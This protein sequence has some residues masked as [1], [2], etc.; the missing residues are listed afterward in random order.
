MIFKNLL[1][2]KGR[3][4]LTMIEI[5]IGVTAIIALG[6]MANGVESG[7][8]K[9]LTGSQA[10]LVL[11]QPD[12][13][14]LSLSSIDETITEQLQAMPEVAR[15][16]GM[17]EGIVQ[18]EGAPYFFVFGYPKDSFVLPRF[19]IIEGVGTD[20]H[21]LRNMRGKPIW[22]GKAASQAMKKKPG[23]IVRLN[24]SAYRV[25]GIF[26]TGEAFE[27]GG[28]VLMLP[29]AQAMLGQER[30][31]SVMYIQLKDKSMG[32]RLQ[33]R[34]ARLWPDLDMTSTADLSSRQ[35][36]GT[37]LQIYVWVIAGLAIVIGGVGMMNAQLMSVFER[38]REIG[39]LRA[40]GW[41]SLRVMG[42]I[43]GES[44]L[45][46]ILGGMLGVFLGWLSLKAAS[47]F[48]SAFGASSSSIDAGL[49]IRAFGTVTVLG[50]VGGL[51]PGLRAARL[52]PV[53]ALR[54]EGGSLN[55]RVV[56]LPVGGMATQSLWQR[57]A[58][59][60]LTLA[61]I[62]ITIGAIMLLDGISGS[63]TGM[64][65][66]MAGGAQIMLEQANVSDTS[67]S[68][69]DERVGDKIAA[70]P[71]V[72]AVA[73][74]TFTAIVMNETGFFM[75]IGQAPNEPGINSYRVIDGRPIVSNHEIMI[76]QQVATALN[77]HVGDT[78]TLSGVRYRIVGIYNAKLSFMEL[79]GVMTLRDAQN[80]TGKPRKVTMYQVWVKNPRQAAEVRDEINRMFPEVHASLSGEFADNMP[81]LQN[82]A[83][84]VN[85]IS[86]MAILVGGLGMM[87]TMLM[88]VL[89]RT[90]E[91]GVLRALGWRRR[92]ILSLIIREAALLGI[93]GGAVGMLIAVGIGVLLAKSGGMA[94][95]MTPQWSLD[96]FARA[97]IVAISLGVVGGLYPALRGTQLQPVEA[98]RYE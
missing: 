51:Y 86:F 74:M 3:T 32:D 7:Y 43:L 77:K 98:L 71:A 94:S 66:G 5:A 1:R 54:Y 38:T 28:A 47:G 88:A 81:D 8:G 18:A 9:A 20:S 35:N 67:Y 92:D 25:A 42:M 34:A 80:F 26:T 64:M 84:M 85:G 12:A 53:E 48:V 69:I 68:A 21:E 10:D 33:E 29:D 30:H 58:R 46:G 4:F 50:L 57:K 91:I 90:R 44:V 52:E 76:G 11:S 45:I 65:E 13:Y 97:L 62:G 79:G 70:L 82:T 40:V 19:Q 73:G 15:V 37:Q 22:I 49:L 24:D 95:A 56:R 96:V 78:I 72:Q 89:E 59:T 23:D 60:I 31:V 87:N 61:A 55:D 6:A 36:M 83:A 17:L 75:I 39:V 27:D 93:L 2:R 16:S 14:D 63:F 41:S